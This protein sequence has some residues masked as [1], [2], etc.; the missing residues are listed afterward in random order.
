MNY[1]NPANLRRTPNV[2]PLYLRPCAHALPPV[3]FLHPLHTH[4]T[5]TS[6]PLHTHL[7]PTL[8]PSFTK[9]PQ[10]SSVETLL[11]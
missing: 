7:N 5:T 3:L 2:T 1:S 10:K 6:Q 11:E 4:F 9:N 8:N